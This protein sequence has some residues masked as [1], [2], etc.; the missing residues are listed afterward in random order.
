MRQLARWKAVVGGCS[1]VAALVFVSSAVAGTYTVTGTCALWR[2]YTNGVEWVSPSATCPQLKVFHPINGLTSP[3]GGEG[4]WVF[5]APAGA[6]VASFTLQGNLLGTNGWQAAVIPAN[7]SPVENCPGSNCPGAY[8]YMFG[9]VQYPGSGSSAIVLRLRCGAAGGCPNSQI[10]SY[11]NIFAASVTV[12]DGTPPAIAI[13]G[14]PILSGWQRAMGTVN[15]DA[16][17][18]VGIKLIRVAVDNR[19]RAEVPRPCDYGSKTPCPS[20]GGAL[21][22]D[23]TG[24]PDG[25]HALTLQAVDSADNTAQDSRTFLVDNTPPATPQT[26]S[27]SSAGAWSA[28]NSFDA[29]WTNP[30]QNASAIAGADYRLCPT[31]NAPGD[32]SGCVTRSVSGTNIQVLRNIDVPKAGSWRMSLYLRDAAGNA[33]VSTAAQL[34]PLQFDPTPPTLS[35]QPVSPDDPTRVRVAASDDT[36][37]V[38][39]RSLE[40][41]LDGTDAWIPVSVTPDAQGFSAALDDGQ[42]ADGTYHLRARVTDAAGNERSVESTPD[43]QPAVIALPVRLKT[44]LAVG[45]VT[46]VRAHA[47]RGGKPR[48]RRILVSRPRSRYG[49]TVR[50]SGRLTTPGANPVVDTDVE[51]WEQFALPGSTWNQIAT[52]RTSRTGRFVFKA[53]RGPSRLVQFRYGGTATVRSRITTVDLRVKATSTMRVN[54]HHVH[55]GDDVTFHGRLQGRPIPAGGKIV[56]LQ[57]YSRRRWRTFGTAR[58]NETTGLWSYRYRFEAI[59]GRVSFRFRARI[60][61]EATYPFD[62]G[63]SRQVRVS[64]RG[65]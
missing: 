30:P 26:A 40:I 31:A 4:G 1:L 65:Q 64:V 51:V 13:N 2:P 56:E 15:Y 43:G 22:V 55:N 44:R 61:K 19:P 36:S 29:R 57:V 16:A 10:D 54:R 45:R 35:F 7:A 38:A 42:L 27:M 34:P 18:N 59:L 14:G 25:P 48:Y 41:R 37:G 62:L 52:V 53:L 23:T 47:S 17:D 9:N 60:R 49:R 8:K 58:A 50:L 21:N 24:M 46:K 32:S 33:D 28:T 11:I 39:T 6:G 12:V 20:G 5:D 63:T 3:V